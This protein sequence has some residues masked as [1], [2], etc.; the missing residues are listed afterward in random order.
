MDNWSSDYPVIWL[1]DFNQPD[2]RT[3]Q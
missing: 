1:I 2:D 3:T